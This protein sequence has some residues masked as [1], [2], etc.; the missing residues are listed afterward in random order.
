M[1]SRFDHAVLSLFTIDQLADPFTVSKSVGANEW[2][3]RQGDT[4]L[5]TI[6][7]TTTFMFSVEKGV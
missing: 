6:R 1:Y 5:G 3:V 4:V 7:R 2:R